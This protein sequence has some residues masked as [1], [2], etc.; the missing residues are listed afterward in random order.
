MKYSKKARKSIALML[1]AVMVTQLL[2]PNVALALTTGPTQP[3]VQSFE[4]VGTTDMVDMFSGDF[5]YNIPLMDVE[6]YPVNIS[7]HGGVTMEQE[8]SWVGLGWNINPGVINRSVRGIPDDFKGDTLSKELHILDEKTFRAGVGAGIEFFGMGDPFL[9]LSASLGANLTFS[10]YRGTS[11]DFNLGAGVNLFRSASVGVNLGI[12]SATGADIDY[13]ANLSLGSTQMVSKD[14]SAGVGVGVS[15]GY[16]SRSGLKDL[17]LT[18]SANAS[19]HG[20]SI[21]QSATNTIPIGVQNF[22]PVITNSNTMNSFYGS[23]KFGGELLWCFGWGKV[24]GMFSRVHYNNDGS[25]DAFGYLYMQESKGTGYHSIMDFTRDKDGQF[26]KTMQYLPPANLTYDIYSVSGQGTGGMFRPYRN[27]FGSVYDPTTHSDAKS[28]TVGLEAGPGWIFELGGNFTHSKTDMSSGPWSTYM[29][30][31]SSRKTGSIYE[32]SYLKQGGELT[33]VDPQYFTDINGFEPIEPSSLSSL[34]SIKANSASKRDP[35]GNMIY[36]HTADEQSIAGVGTNPDIVSYTSLNGFSAGAVAPTTNISRIGSNRL[37][38]KKDEISEIVQ[39]Q[40]DGKKYIYGIPALNHIQKEATFSV[41]PP[42][43]TDMSKGLVNYTPFSDD[44]VSNNKGMEHYYSSTITPSYAHSYLLTAVESSDYVDVTGNGPSDDDLGSYTKMNYSLKDPDYRWKAPFESGKAQY[45]PGYRSDKKDDK[46]SY[47]SGSREQWLLHSIETKNFVAEFYTSVRNDGCGSQD[48]IVNSGCY[49]IAPYNVSLS[50]PGKS[51]KLDSI[52]LY[53][54][55]DRFINKTSAIPVKTVFFTYNDDLCKGIPNVLGGSGAAGKLTLSNIYFRYGNSQRSMISPYQ[56]SYGYNPNYDLSQKDRWGNYKPGSPTITNYEFPFVDQNDTANNTYASAWSLTGISLPSGGMIQASYES[57]DYA[58][59]QDKTASEMF[60]IK[61]VG[62]GRKFNKSTYLY[63]GSEEPYLYLYFARRISSELPKLSFKENYLK[64]TDIIYYNVSLGLRYA[65]EQFKGY[66]KITDI[67]KC[68]DSPQY[69]YIVLEPILRGEKDKLNPIS[70][71]AINTARYNIPHILF[72]GSYSDPDEGFGMASG[73]SDA[74]DELIGIFKSKNLII[75]L[76]KK[77]VA[78]AIDKNKS[79]IRLQ[80]P[81]L[82]KKG[83]GQ[84]VKSLFFYD[85]WNALA[86]GNEQSATYGKNY[87]YTMSDEKHGV[88]SSGV[89]SYEPM[90]GGDENPFRAPVPY[91]ARSGSA[92]PPNDAVELYQE[93]PIGESLFPPASVGY[94]KVTISSIHSNNAK[95]AR[96][97]DVYQFYTAK[98]FPVQMKP[99]AINSTFTH[100]FSFFSQENDMSAT[101]GYALVL[102]DMHGKP[103]SVEHF[104]QPLKTRSLQ[105]VSYQTY[106]YKMKDGQLDNNVK[107]IIYDPSSQSMVVRDQQLGVE[108]D[109]TIDTRQRNEETKNSTYNANLNVSGFFIFIL[110]IFMAYKWPGKYATSFRSATVTKVVQQYGILDNVQAL[111]EGAVTIQKNEIFDP[112]TGQVVV[113]SVNN[114]FQDKEYTVNLPAYWSYIGMSPGYSSVKYD[115]LIPSLAIDAT[116]MGVFESAA[117]FNVGD[118]LLLDYDVSGVHY[119]EIAWFM[120]SGRLKGNTIGCLP[121][122]HGFLLPRYPLS[123]PGWVAMDTLRNVHAKVINPGAKNMLN[124][125]IETYTMMD[126]PIDPGGT[127]KVALNNV[128]SINAKTFSDSNTRIPYRYI[129]NADTINPF[130]IGER[131]IYRTLDEYA[132]V[133]NRNYSGTTSRNAGLFNAT[134]LYSTPGFDKFNCI[135]FPYNYIAPDAT[136]TNWR[137]ARTITKW[138]PNGKEVENKD[139]VGNYSSAVYGYNEELPTAVASNARQG[140]VLADGFEYY[141]LLH[142]TPNL[143]E[144]FYSPFSRFF[145]TTSLTPSSPAY[146]LYN[147][148]NISTIP[149]ILATSAHTGKYSLAI[150]AAGASGYY[151]MSLPINTTSYLG[152]YNNYNSYFPNVPG[153]SYL[154]SRANE[155]LPFQLSRGNKYLLSFWVKQS[156]SPANPTTYNINDSCGIKVDGTFYKL[157]K[158]SNIIE[159]WQQVE[160]AFDV[161]AWASAATLRLPGNYNID[162]IRFFPATANMK[163][164]VY[165]PINEKLMGTL[166]ENNFATLYEYDQE[167]NLIRVK[168]ETEKGIMTISESRSNNPKQ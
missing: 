127:L 28:Y 133:A 147:L 109:I 98:D 64:D 12:G 52:K 121:C 66:A 55:H 142:S 10:N 57:D 34:P 72:P 107:C 45:D 153:L 157:S 48:R 119:Q 150:P 27:D 162:D 118:Q 81:G 73:I 123:T 122:C 20:G 3:E 156:S 125:T 51:Y 78:G 155:Y 31:Y 25:K 60:L 90:I 42:S 89:A 59:V 143:T 168:K 70:Y 68:T 108:A 146:N 96:G 18:F 38:H 148:T 120:G 2:L 32:E 94:S 69:G 75:D 22:V 116:H 43:S 37:E 77:G 7:Y 103:K 36:Y 91:I 6:G 19:S 124:E 145:G 135:Q 63:S 35:R 104:I 101:Q 50:S 5:V 79:F 128:I 33:A 11:C 4:P 140:E 95:S 112:E 54:K 40:K 62:K 21:S 159:G 131:G 87:S 126:N 30:G 134:I 58:Y 13:D 24:S 71:T 165:N 151:G 115:A 164:F 26:N 132:Y 67:G 113:T 136:N 17:N 92:W 144:L 9:T 167:G 154:F 97:V 117:N 53:N 39:L 106:N 23:I 61:G 130:A 139:A 80:C 129:A 137:I 41:N 44:D 100:H 86:G 161:P 110:P 141:N 105:M 8:A 84:R 111:N 14:L 76:I 82:K 1:F 56:F 47:V 29:R 93:T 85:S 74:F 166:D 46:G 65:A 99:T 138:S 158:K 114:E 163:A 152:R 102:N 15:Q 88:I 49:N 83:G 16:S 149:S 160:V